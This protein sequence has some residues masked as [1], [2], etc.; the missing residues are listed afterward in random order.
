MTPFT[1]VVLT[2]REVVFDGKITSLILPTTDGAMGFMAGRERTTVEVVAGDLKFRSAER[3]H[4]LE[5]DGGV[6]EMTGSTMT[7]LCGT[8][9][10]KDEAESKKEARSLELDEA[11]LRQ[12]KS[13]AEYKINRAALIRAFDKIRRA[14][15]K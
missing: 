12:E 13:L 2:P 11:R 6:A 10:D 7:I 8:A 1:L 4:V 15:I 5:T 3:D 9:Y 14:R